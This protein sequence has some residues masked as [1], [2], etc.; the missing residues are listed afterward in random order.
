MALLF[1]NFE[2]QIFR[3]K[4]NIGHFMTIRPLDSVCSTSEVL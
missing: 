2:L 1:Q 3:L 4:A